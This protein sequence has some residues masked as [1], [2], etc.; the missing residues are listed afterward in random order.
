MQR[1]WRLNEVRVDIKVGY[2][3]WEELMQTKS[4]P[5]CNGTHEPGCCMQR[6]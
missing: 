4:G 2:E 5:L 1:H 6:G 3:R